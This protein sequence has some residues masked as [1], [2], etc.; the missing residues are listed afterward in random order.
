MPNIHIIDINLNCTGPG[1]LKDLIYGAQNVK[2]YD[3]VNLR[4]EGASRH[5]TYRAVNAIGPVINNGNT[6]SDYH[7][8]CPQTKH[9][10]QQF[11]FPS[12]FSRIGSTESRA[13]EKAQR[14]IGRQDKY[15]SRYNIPTN[16]IFEHLN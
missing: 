15:Q 2:N 7:L 5:F 16:N 8:T 12:K 9:Q 14:S 1:Y 3:G 13:N 4:G 10:A 11:K 6:A